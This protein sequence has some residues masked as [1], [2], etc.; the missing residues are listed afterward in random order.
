MAQ[1]NRGDRAPALKRLG[2]TTK[3]TP[4]LI[5]NKIKALELSSEQTAQLSK[6]YGEIM[7]RLQRKAPK[8]EINALRAD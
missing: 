5:A 2:I 3:L 1:F 4:T 7:Q 8:L 6:L